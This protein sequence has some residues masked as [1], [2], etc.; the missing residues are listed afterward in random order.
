M[1]PIAVDFIQP[2]GMLL[3]CSYLLTRIGLGE[4]ID[5]QLGLVHPGYHR[6][7]KSVGHDCRRPRHVLGVK[8]EL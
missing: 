4:I 8:K 1:P 5:W 2:S 3:T 7:G 6:F